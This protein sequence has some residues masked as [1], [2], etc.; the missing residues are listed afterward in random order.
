MF[1]SKGIREASQWS[2]YKCLLLLLCWGPTLSWEVYDPHRNGRSQCLANS[3]IWRDFRVSTLKMQGWGAG[4]R[5]LLSR[6]ITLCKQ[7]GCCLFQRAN[8]LAFPPIF[9]PDFFMFNHLHT[10]AFG[11]APGYGVRKDDGKEGGDHS[12]DWRKSTKVM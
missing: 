5:G 9:L 8:H 11:D 10:G 2:S 7:W 6:V 4:T 1:L 3:R 12:P